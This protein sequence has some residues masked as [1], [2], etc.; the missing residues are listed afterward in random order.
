MNFKSIGF[1]AAVAT[2]VVAGSAMSMAPAEAGNL[3][4]GAF[5]L[6]GK[7]S[8]SVNAPT[9]NPFTI[10]F[11]KFLIANGTGNNSDAPSG[12]FEN[13]LT[14]TPVVGSLTLQHVGVKDEYKIIA[15]LPNFVT[16][17]KQETKAIVLGLSSGSL[18]GT[19][20]DQNNYA[21]HTDVHNPL[22][23]TLAFAPPNSGSSPAVVG[24][25]AFRFQITSK[26][27]TNQASIGVETIPTPALLPGLI[28]MG[29]AALR[30]RKFEE[31][32]MEA[33]ETAK[34]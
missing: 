3:F 23:A 33:A 1:K 32:D 13:N 6:D 26:K 9:N 28:G 12:V 17:L 15:G 31:S 14:G 29:I 10:N 5:F 7:S 4:P 11:S 16:K 19:I 34:A 8:I 18:F 30:K 27:M 2:A 20:T 25:G 21:F 24:L 22:R